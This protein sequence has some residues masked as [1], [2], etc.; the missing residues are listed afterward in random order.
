MRAVWE[1][2]ELTEIEHPC[3]PFRITYASFDDFWE[4][5]SVP[6]GPSGVAIAKL[7]ADKKDELKNL[8]RQRLPAQADGAISYEPFANAVKG[9]VY[10]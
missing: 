8:L 6:V 2:N 9:R 3:H 1:E 10:K 5:N 7:S 4:S